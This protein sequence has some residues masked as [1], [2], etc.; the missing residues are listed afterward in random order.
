[1][2]H[3]TGA[4]RTAAAEA[5]QAAG[6]GTSTK[7]C[8]ASQ[9]LFRYTDVVSTSL[10]ARDYPSSRN[11]QH[12]QCIMMLATLFG[13]HSLTDREQAAWAAFERSLSRKNYAQ[14]QL[15][16]SMIVNN[17]FEFTSSMAASLGAYRATLF[18]HHASSDGEDD[19]DS[20]S[21][22]APSTTT[23]PTAARAQPQ[24]FAM[25]VRNELAIDPY[26]TPG[27]LVFEPPETHPGT[28]DACP[29]AHIAIMDSANANAIAHA[30]DPRV[31]TI[32][33]VVRSLSSLS[34]DPAAMRQLCVLG[35][36]GALK[37]TVT[38]NPVAIPLEK[39][40]AV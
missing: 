31:T 19:D 34:I 26:T 8:D 3:I 2:E 12:I 27:Y 38:Q 28:S 13:T 5:R 18:D 23:T 35:A 6:T 22:S 33:G 24:S 30:S 14:L 39:P 25:R 1:M 11:A 29:R 10:Y 9:L 40:I 36:S 20:S 21:K 7:L 4:V 15:D 17:A 37:A 32:D 16:P